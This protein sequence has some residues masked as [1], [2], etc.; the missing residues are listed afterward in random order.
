VSRV[1]RRA[2][3]LVALAAAA[4]F[5]SGAC[6]RAGPRQG[7][8]PAGGGARLEDRSGPDAGPGPAGAEEARIRLAC[9][10]C[11]LLPPPD[12]L[13][14]ARWP[15]AIAGM[16]AVPV[17][18]GEPPLRPEDLTFATDYYLRRA[19]EALAPTP[20]AKDPEEG[21]PSFSTAHFTPPGLE[22]LRLPAVAAV[23][24]V[25][26]ARAAGA[27]RAAGADRAAGAVPPSLLAAEMRS[28]TLL[29]LT[30]PGEGGA[31][32]L[33]PLAGALNY[34]VHIEP[35]DFDQDG[36]TDLLVPGIGGMDPSN[37][38]N[39]SVFLLSARD[40]A[41]ETAGEA[42]GGDGFA[43]R[44]IASGIARP[45]DARAADLDRDGD[46]DLA[47][48]AF[49]WRGPGSLLVLED[50]GAAAAERFSPHVLDDR[51]GYIHVEPADL[52]ADGDLDLVALL[53]QEHE[54]VV[55][56]LNQGGLRFALRVIY[57]A[58]HPSWGFSGLQLA[59]LDRDGD[60]DILTTN[61]DSL[62]HDVLKPYHGIQWIENLDG[63][64]FREERL[65][66]LHGSSQ[67]VASDLD[68]DGD[69]DIVAVAFLPLLRPE[70]W[71]EH[72]LDSIVWIEQDGG[73]W[74]LRSLERFLC[75]HPTVDVADFD[76]DGKP[77]I[78]AGNYVWLSR[79]T[80]PHARADYVTVLMAR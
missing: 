10:R 35:H 16:G 41:G 78:A 62:D 8:A 66:A 49:G 46:L 60:L 45:A 17:R 70:E 80:G 73:V 43:P 31:R 52:D 51:D 69:L 68:Q 22:E 38:V 48:T 3:L 79:K 75:M 15:E 4:L 11:H 32:A 27:E 37:D 54:E 13:P 55:A 71:R 19:P 21:D 33:L 1:E 24:F 65:A 57:K 40:S 29:R 63:L 9:A 50:R 61:G 28:R 72:A 12:A 44:E 77:D 34:P 39:G 56:F 26:L 5:G 47:V 36:R 18:A 42:A 7:A 59:D 14:R 30:S 74:S 2:A 20:R 6:E 58:P 23:R 64:D 76:A 25:H 67:A 53:S